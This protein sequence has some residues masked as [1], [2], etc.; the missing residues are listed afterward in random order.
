MTPRGAEPV[1]DMA[2]VEAAED[3]SML[4]DLLRTI[5]L[6]IWQRDAIAGFA[7]HL[8]GDDK[9]MQR[10]LTAIEQQQALQLMRT[11]GTA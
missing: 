10:T 8:A 1:E 7:W 4:D 11:E 5:D 3:L 9:G 6:L 2:H